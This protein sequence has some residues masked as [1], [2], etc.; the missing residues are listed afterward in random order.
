MFVS[1]SPWKVL[2]YDFFVNFMDHFVPLQ[3]D[4]ATSFPRSLRKVS[5]RTETRPLRE[6]QIGRTVEGEE[7]RQKA[8]VTEKY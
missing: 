1:L 2:E 7:T 4:P 8:M 3:L 5:L 6:K